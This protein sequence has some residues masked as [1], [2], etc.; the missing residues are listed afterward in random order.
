MGPIH[1]FVEAFNRGDVTEIGDALAPDA[2]A[3]VL[4]APFPEEQGRDVILR[5][6]IPHLLDGSLRA[7]PVDV[8][9]APGVVLCTEDGAIDVAVLVSVDEVHVTQLHYVTGPHEPDRL[10]AVGVALGRITTV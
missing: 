8:E 4:G 10:R 1:R 3:R 5:T 7:E 6:S 2:S 9:G